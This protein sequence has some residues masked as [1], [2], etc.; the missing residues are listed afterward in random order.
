MKHRAWRKPAFQPTSLIAGV[1]LL[2]VLFVAVG[3]FFFIGT[4]GSSPERQAMLSELQLRR[5]EWLEK[6]PPAFRYEVERVCECPLDYIKPFKVV[7]YLDE[8]DNRSWIDDYFVRL[9][10][11]MGSA[12]TV[13]IRYD[14]RYSYPNDFRI[15]DEQVFV[16]DFEVLQYD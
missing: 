11:A 10:E 6:R 8:P 9:E 14:P 7:E 16:R 12:D 1:F 5:G 2:L 15:D 13:V 4:V 3:Y